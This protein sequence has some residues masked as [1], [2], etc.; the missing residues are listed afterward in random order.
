MKTKKLT[1]PV[2]LLVIAVVCVSV[3]AVLSNA[4][5]SPTV[6]EAEFPFSV[7]YEYAGSTETVRDVFVCSFTDGE[8]SGITQYRYW[9]GFLAS[10]G[11]DSESSSYFLADANG[12]QFML[13]TNL[14]AGYLMGDPLYADYHD[15]EIPYEPVVAYY[16]SD[17][18]EHTDG[19]VL[20]S[21][22]LKIVS[23]EYPEAIE[24]EFVF[25][26]V[27]K[28]DG[29][30]VLPMTLTAV[31]FLIAA[32]LFVKKDKDFRHIVT[33]TVSVTVS[34][35]SAFLF[36]PFITVLSMFLELG[37]S[38][39]SLDYQIMFGTPALAVL[40]LAASVCLRRKGFAKSSLAVQ[41]IAPAVYTACLIAGLFV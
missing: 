27:D 10:Q 16:D 31:A 22:G 1:F 19:R 20:D 3:S 38:A 24:N 35:L 8:A 6:T 28:L 18:V 41:F 2:I 11:T 37:G 26:H 36:I 4:V 29:S 23:W 7:T 32:L 14:F 25:S 13:L 39:D 5:Y 9:S 34:F 21:Y 33:N 17:G 40:C 30:S 12:G 15:S